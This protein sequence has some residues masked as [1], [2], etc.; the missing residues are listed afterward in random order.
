MIDIKNFLQMGGGRPETGGFF[1][2]ILVYYFINVIIQT[3]CIS[4]SFIL[5]YVIYFTHSYYSC[6]DV[7]FPSPKNGTLAARN[8]SSPIVFDL[9]G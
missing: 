6:F 1:F 2:Y 8:E 4:S 7:F 5:V 9:D 3:L